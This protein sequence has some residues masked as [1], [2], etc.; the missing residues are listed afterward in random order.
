MRVM[1][2]IRF[3]LG[4]TADQPV[5]N[6]WAGWPSASGVYP[7]L[8]LQAIVA[9][10][11]DPVT[12]YLINIAHIDRL[13]R[14]RSIPAAYRVTSFG[15]ATG[16]ALIQEIVHDLMDH[17]LD[18]TRWEGWNLKITPYLQYGIQAG[19]LNMVH[20]TQ[21]FEFSAAH[22]LHCPSMSDAENRDYF[23][24]CNNPNG[25]GHNYQ[26]EITVSGEPSKS[27]GVVIPITQFEQVVKEQVIN[28][29]DHKHL[30][31]D[32]PEFA[33]LNPSVEHIA[34]VI[35]SVLE[36]HFG[37]ASLTSVRVWETPKTWAE[38]RG[39]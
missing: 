7:Y 36:G 12:G 11:A 2:E 29:F 37:E 22:R 10:Q 8:T 30:N 9:G 13:L 32:C 27:T 34:K 28:R 3:S 1:R 4:P 19:T 5:T 20:V 31:E 39:E 33:D 38:Y 16:E 15:P 25:H 17:V 24:K 18:G 23:G 6:S 35:W 26:V 14:E 21:S